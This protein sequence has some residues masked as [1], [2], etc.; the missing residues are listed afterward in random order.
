MPIFKTVQPIGMHITIE[1]STSEI[2]RVHEEFKNFAQS[3]LDN[4]DSISKICI[5]IDE[6]LS[7]I[8]NHGYPLGA[9]GL[10]DVSFKLNEDIL[11]ITFSDKGQ[12][13]NPLSVLPPDT[14]LPLELRQEGKLGI[15]IM[16]SFID[17]AIYQR[18]GAYNLLT[19][20]KNV[21]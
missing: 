19:L 15:H 2:V 4:K 9:E 18:Q 20:K 12:A 14:T 6:V 7:N 11:T 21:K 16:R 3:S 13:F 17:D 5:V 10:I 1:N 8:I